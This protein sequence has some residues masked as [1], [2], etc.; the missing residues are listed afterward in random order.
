[1]VTQGFDSLILDCLAAARQVL[2]ARRLP[3]VTLMAEYRGG[4]ATQ[5]TWLDIGGRP[6]RIGTP[7]CLSSLDIANP[8]SCTDDSGFSVS[9]RGIWTPD[10]ENEFCRG[11]GTRGKR[12]L[13]PFPSARGQGQPACHCL[14][15]LSRNAG[16]FGCRLNFRPILKRCGWNWTWDIPSLTLCRK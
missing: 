3:L 8:G 12:G 15:C 7:W 9:P 16:S 5:E 11:L 1:M 14:P 2:G 6:G 13:F 10:R 4:E